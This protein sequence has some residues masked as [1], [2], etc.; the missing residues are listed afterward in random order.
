L[1]EWIAGHT[2]EIEAA[3]LKDDEFS[4]PEARSLI[5]STLNKLRRFYDELDLKTELADEYRIKNG[6]DSPARRVSEDVTY[7]V[8]ERRAL[9]FNVMNILYACIAAG[10]CCMVEV[11]NMRIML[12]KVQAYHGTSFRRI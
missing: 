3:A 6:Q 8:P 7:V 10:S 12:P 11:G 2:S 5:T 9:F 1:H 4:Q